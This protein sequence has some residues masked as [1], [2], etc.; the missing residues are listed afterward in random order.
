MSGERM[1]ARGGEEHGAERRQDDDAGVGGLIGVDAD[2]DH[3]RR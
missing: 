1:P 3:R 2:E